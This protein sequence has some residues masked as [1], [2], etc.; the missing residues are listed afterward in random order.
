MK[1]ETAPQESQEY[2][3]HFQSNS[4]LYVGMGTL[5]SRGCLLQPYTERG[6]LSNL[7]STIDKTL[8]EYYA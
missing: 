4:K 1:Q 3:V 2:F 6:C 5:Y 7:L 8:Y